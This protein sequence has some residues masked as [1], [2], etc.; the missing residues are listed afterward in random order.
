M[1]GP[2]SYAGHAVP[3]REN[4]REALGAL[5]VLTEWKGSDRCV[6]MCVRVWVK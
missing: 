4:Q 2:L 1:N 5:L 6:I 3:Y